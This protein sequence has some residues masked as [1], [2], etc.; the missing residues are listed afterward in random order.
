LV[1]RVDVVSNGLEATQAANQFSYDLIL[2]DCQMPEMDGLTATRLIRS[3]MA[4]ELPI[5]ALTANAFKE[6]EEQSRAAGMSDFM[7]KPMTIDALRLMLLNWLP[8]FFAL[9]D[10]S[11]N[12][13]SA[14]PAVPEPTTES[15]PRTEQQSIR[16]K[17]QEL[18]ELM[19]ADTV[20]QLLAL[21]KTETER[22]IAKARE[23]LQTGDLDG[24]RKTA[25]RL[26]G[27]VLGIGAEPLARQCIKLQDMAHS[28]NRD[29]AGPLLSQIVT[30]AGRVLTQL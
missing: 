14:K 26:A 27:A 9:G 30:H 21:F 28:G 20:A 23:Q 19:G 29:E 11:S 25:H 2:M 15:E 13:S 4:G 8:Q 17:I 22:G 18:T 12:E 7:T 6:D 24:L 1:W 10:S 5:I 16:A 3:R